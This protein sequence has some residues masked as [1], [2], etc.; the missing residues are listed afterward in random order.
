MQNMSWNVRYRLWRL[1]REANPSR[2]FSFTLETDLKHKMGH[3]LWW[4]PI[5]RI[6][7]A[8]G[9]GALLVGGGTVVYATTSQ[10]V[11]PGDTLYGI[12]HAVQQV[13][14][15]SAASQDA[16]QAMQR[17]HELMHEQ[18]LQRLRLRTENRR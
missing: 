7:S 3:D 9:L 12:R 4:L 1:S 5:G 10:N 8:I 2:E 14:E 11:L 18:D 16:R 15:A 13:E 6:A 17:Q